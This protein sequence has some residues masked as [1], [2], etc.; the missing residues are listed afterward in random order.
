MSD[1]NGSLRKSVDGIDSSD[2]VLLEKTPNSSQREKQQINRDTIIFE[3]EKKHQSPSSKTPLLYAKN[4]QSY[5]EQQPINE[6]IQQKS[7]AAAFL[8]SSSS[9][10]FYNVKEN[11]L[12]NIDE[13]DAARGAEEVEEFV[14][15][16]NATTEDSKCNPFFN[17]TI[18]DG[19]V[20]EVFKGRHIL[21]VNIF[22]YLD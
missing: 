5:Q 8:S 3:T 13:L 4:V 12:K 20:K 21:H 6:Q 18:E 22:N 1:D 10:N 19:T 14:V 7:V 11:D 2:V 16:K 15:R 9:D 17:S